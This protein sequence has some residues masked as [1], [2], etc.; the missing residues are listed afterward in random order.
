VP[1][2]RKT[3]FNSCSKKSIILISRFGGSTIL[4][5]PNVTTVSTNSQIQSVGDIPIK[6]AF[7][8]RKKT[9]I[10]DS[11]YVNWHD[12]LT[13]PCVYNPTMCPLIYYT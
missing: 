12:S 8:T 3:N 5:F 9:I 13:P 4:S 1:S 10:K 11:E 2:G 7:L 6:R